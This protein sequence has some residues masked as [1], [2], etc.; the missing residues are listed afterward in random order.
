MRWYSTPN[1]PLVKQNPRSHMVPLEL[2][3]M[4][5]GLIV[6]L[7]LGRILLGMVFRIF[8]P[9]EFLPSLE[10][11]VLVRGMLG[12][13]RSPGHLLGTITLVPIYYH[14]ITH[15]A[16]DS[17]SRAQ[18]FSLVIASIP[19]TFAWRYV[20]LGIFGM[21]P[22]LTDLSLW[23]FSTCALTCCLVIRHAILL[24]SQSRFSAS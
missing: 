15:K 10:L 18:K 7:V 6:L 12:Q 17:G 11:S 5:A 4:S 16:Y 8:A 14:V 3:W 9:P 19:L 23:V 20:W 24:T 2:F 22:R 21:S 13:L 1:R